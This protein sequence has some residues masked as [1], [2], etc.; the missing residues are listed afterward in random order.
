MSPNAAEI[1]TA[2]GEVAYE[3]QLD[4]D[5]LIWSGNAADVLG[6]ADPAEIASGRAFA[7]K[8]E[9]QPGQNRF[10][11]VAHTEQKDNGSG[12]AYELQYGFQPQRRQHLA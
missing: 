10:E 5:A 9:A 6:V 1:L 2:V 12:V 11:V 7:Q 4:T 8:V 3:W